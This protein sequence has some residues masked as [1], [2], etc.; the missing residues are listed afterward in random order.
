MP[1]YRVRQSSRDGSLRRRHQTRRPRGQELHPTQLRAAELKPRLTSKSRPLTCSPACRWLARTANH[2]AT[3]SDLPSVEAR[4][5][6]RADPRRLSR[7]RRQL[8]WRLSAHV[9]RSLVL[10]KS[11]WKAASSE[12]RSSAPPWGCFSS[13]K[14]TRYSTTTAW[15][16]LKLKASSSSVSVMARP[17]GS[18]SARLNSHQDS[19]SSGKGQESNAVAIRFDL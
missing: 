9:S 3:H 1:R 19:V 2:S 16:G 11:S 17:R 7:L 12:P 6:V 4:H 14:G 8:F 5:L 10:P 15:V 18:H 13:T